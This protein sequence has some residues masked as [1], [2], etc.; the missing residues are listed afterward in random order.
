[1]AKKT[2]KSKPKS[3]PKKKPKLRRDKYGRF[4]GRG[5]P[6]YLPPERDGRGRFV[7]KVYKPSKIVGYKN[8]KGLGDSTGSYY[9]V[10]T[11]EEVFRLLRKVAPSPDNVVSFIFDQGSSFSS[12]FLF[13]WQGDKEIVR[14][15]WFDVSTKTRKYQVEGEVKRTILIREPTGADDTPQ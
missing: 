6:S 14:R 11:L 4:I 8:V 1:M 9:P 2:S 13:V 3:K 12:S 10:A 15:A 5:E 7:K